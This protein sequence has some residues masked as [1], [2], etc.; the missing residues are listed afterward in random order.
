MTFNLWIPQRLY[1]EALDLGFG[2][3]P[4]AAEVE[5][6]AYEAAAR[7]EEGRA[8]RCLTL[9]EQLA[10]KQRNT[11]KPVERKPLGKQIRRRLTRHQV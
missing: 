1:D 11:F 4:P 5:A 6:A 8:E 7:G 9:A 10:Y 2:G 3:Y